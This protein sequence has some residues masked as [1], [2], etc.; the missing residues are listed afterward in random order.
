MPW[1]RRQRRQQQPA[2]HQRDAK[3]HHPARTEAIHHAADQRTDDGGY[4]KAERERTR[5]KA[6]LPPELTDD[7][8]KEQ[9]E[10]RPRIDADRHGDEGHRNDQPAVEEGKMHGGP[11]SCC[12]SFLVV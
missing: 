9:R 8:R 3:L 12:L 11:F 6:S 4:Y 7:R 5:G 1:L 10:R 2:A